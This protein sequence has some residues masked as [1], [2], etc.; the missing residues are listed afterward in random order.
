M[1]FGAGMRR[2]APRNMSASCSPSPAIRRGSGILDAAFDRAISRARSARPAGTGAGRS[3]DAPRSR[4]DPSV[5]RAQD[6]RRASVRLTGHK[7]EPCSSCGRHVRAREPE[8]G[9]DCPRLGPSTIAKA[10]EPPRVQRKIGIDCIA[11]IQNSNRL[12]IGVGSERGSHRLTS[13]IRGRRSPRMIQVP[14]LSATKGRL[15]FAPPPAS[16]ISRVAGAKRR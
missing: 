9:S 7:I 10:Q 11:P 3:A 5:A 14:R 1:S 8:E 2:A 16:L 15:A 13:S 4:C 12:Q 6:P